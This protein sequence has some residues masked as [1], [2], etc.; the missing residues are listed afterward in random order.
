MSLRK[1][2]LSA[3][4]LHVAAIRGNL[5]LLNKVLDS[6]KVYVD[7]KDEDGTTALIL[8][9]ANNHYE[10]AK[11]LLSQGADPSARRLTG[12]TALFFAA[13]AGYLEIVELLLKHGASVNVSSIVCKISF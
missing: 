1:E 12:T 3:Q 11:E 10:C 8:A 6:G 2:T 4:Q 5:N 7:C 13:Q 9:C